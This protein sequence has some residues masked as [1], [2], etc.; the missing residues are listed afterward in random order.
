V[1]PVHPRTEQRL[2]QSGIKHHAQ[3]RR[4][5]P[6]GYLDFLLLLSKATL[7]LTDSGGIQEETTAL[8]VPCLTLRDNTERPVTVSQGTNV[9]VGTNASKIVAATQQILAGEGKR[10]RS[11]AKNKPTTSRSS[12]WSTAGSSAAAFFGRGR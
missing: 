7:V 9:L 2:S 10:G 11:L 1:F 12:P 3:L 5:Q 4:I 8:G 6:L